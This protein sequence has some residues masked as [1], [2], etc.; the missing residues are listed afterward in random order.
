[1]PSVGLSSEGAGRR[2]RGRWRG[3]PRARLASFF[4]LVAAAEAAELLVKHGRNELEEKRKSHLRLFYEQA[5][6]ERNYS[7]PRASLTPRPPPPPSLWSQCRASSGSRV[8]A[9]LRGCSRAGMLTLFVNS[10]VGR[11][12]HRAGPVHQIRPSVGGLRG[13]VRHPAAERRAPATKLPST[14]VFYPSPHPTPRHTRLHQLL[15]GG[16]SWRRGGGAEGVAEGERHREARRCAHNTS[17]P[18]ELDS[19]IYT[20]AFSVVL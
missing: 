12:H 2:P 17:P 11:S 16:Q 19:H 4:S 10:S 20:D 15:R 3:G 7:V 6:N 8:R 5:R 14:L 18:T 1:M 9:G 13:P